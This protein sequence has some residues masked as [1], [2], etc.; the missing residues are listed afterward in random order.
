MDQCNAC[1]NK[2]CRTVERFRG[3]GKEPQYR[4]Q[5]MLGE[6]GGCTRRIKPVGMTVPLIQAAMVANA[7]GVHTLLSRFNMSIVELDRKPWFKILIHK[8]KR[9]ERWEGQHGKS[10]ANRKVKRHTG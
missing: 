1:M 9:R 8:P 4:I 3:K 10:S 6:G 5:Q 2:R 7:Q